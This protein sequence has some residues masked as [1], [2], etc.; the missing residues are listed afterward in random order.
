M[1]NYQ[2]NA[3]LLLPTMI[4]IHDKSFQLLI[5][6]SEIMERVVAIS[7]KINSDYLN[8]K[9]LFIGVLNGSFMFAAELFKNLE[10]GAEITFLRVQSYQ[11]MASQGKVVEVLGLTE[12]I[13]NREVIIVEDIV[14]TGLTINEIVSY[15]NSKNP[16]S[17]KI[18]T[19]LFKP[20]ALKTDVK[21]D[22]VGFEIEPKFVVGYGLDYDGLGRNL[23]GIFVLYE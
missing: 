21:A 6:E 4:Q 17:I 7:Q 12:N 3:Q 14:D 11:N 22:Y 20:K 19:L 23:R 1:Q 15:L 18:A 8:K 16:N 9:P 2:K 5:S 10:I 13:E